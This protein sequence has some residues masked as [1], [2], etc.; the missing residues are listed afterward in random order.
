MVFTA[1][2][3]AGAI[4][5]SFVAR[6]AAAVAIERPFGRGLSRGQS[7]RFLAHQMWAGMRG[8]LLTQRHNFAVT[9][10]GMNFALA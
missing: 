4:A 3:L 10:S 5:S 9:R 6:S 2:R 1:V 7:E 8:L